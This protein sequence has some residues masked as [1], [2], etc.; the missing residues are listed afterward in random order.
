MQECRLGGLLYQRLWSPTLA[1]QGWGTLN[2]LEVCIQKPQISP[3]R[4]APV[5]MTKLDA[6]AD[7]AFVGFSDMGYL[8]SSTGMRSGLKHS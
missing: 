1:P 3:L 8:V 7:R 2:L 4:F 5:E 6:A